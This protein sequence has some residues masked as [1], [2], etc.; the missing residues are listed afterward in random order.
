MNQYLV[1]YVCD[2]P[3]KENIISSI[4]LSA[5]KVNYD[6]LIKWRKQIHIRDVVRL[7]ILNFVKLD[8]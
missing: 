4:I 7:A 8:D 3:T 2:T 1:T 6:T 5:D